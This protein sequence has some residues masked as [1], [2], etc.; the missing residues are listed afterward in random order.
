[1][2]D[3]ITAIQNP[4]G[5]R[6]GENGIIREPTIFMKQGEVDFLGGKRFVVRSD[7]ITGKCANHDVRWGIGFTLDTPPATT[8]PLP[9]GPHRGCHR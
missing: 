8:L 4:L 2:I 7:D 6:C 5:H 3:K 1:M 9:A